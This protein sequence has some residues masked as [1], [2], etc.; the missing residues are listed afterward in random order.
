M[1][2]SLLFALMLMTLLILSAC[3]A[4]SEEPAADS[5]ESA[6]APT[7]SM[8][9]S[10]A[11][12]MSDDDMADTMSDDEMMDD[13]MMD[14]D[15][16]SSED[17][18]HSEMAEDEMADDMSDDE[19]MADDM[20]SEDEAMADDSMDAMA[21]LPAWQTV[22]L[23]DART[24]ETYTFADFHGQTVFVEPMATWCT[25]CRRQLGD[26]ATARQ[27]LDGEDVVFVA[28][29]VETVLADGD[30]AS[31]ADG[32][33]WPWTFSVLTD[34][35]LRLMVEEF[36]QT[37]ANPPSTPHFIIR[38]DGTFTELDTGFESAEELVAQIQAAMQ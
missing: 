14:D 26:V 7:E 30:L 23:T 20:M 34:E 5:A 10:M 6:P 29:S 22:A 27:T 11:D 37:F 18:A 9:E 33:G 17:D 3:G 19:A 24:G 16:M 8:D 12:E 32:N 2:K 25:N 4:S 35:G 31:Y 1:K 21:D 28:L 13:E 15:D 38:P 36:G